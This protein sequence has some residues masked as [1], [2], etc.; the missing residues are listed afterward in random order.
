ML[1]SHT[2]GLRQ[3]QGRSRVSLWSLYIIGGP[4][5]AVSPIITYH[6]AI[7]RCKL[8]NLLGVK[9]YIIAVIRR[10]CDFLQNIFLFYHSYGGSERG[11]GGSGVYF[12]P[13]YIQPISTREGKNGFICL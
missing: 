10:C 8:L 6:F 3:T 7:I 2:V 5:A 9:V 11:P 12:P 1:G 4:H 13:V